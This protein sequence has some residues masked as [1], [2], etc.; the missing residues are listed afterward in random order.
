MLTE[1][2]LFQIGLIKGEDLNNH[3][4]GEPDMQ[5]KEGDIFK[6]CLNGMEYGIKKIVNR[7]VLLESKDG[8]KQILTEVDSLKIKSFY[9]K[10]EQ[11]KI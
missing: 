3:R 5:T 7:M 6:S 2:D 1:M 10:L 4:I 11:N 9:Q 8:R